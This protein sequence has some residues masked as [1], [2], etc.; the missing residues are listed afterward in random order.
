MATLVHEIWETIDDR[1]GVLPSLELAGP[2]GDDLRKR[3]H[4]DAHEEGL[5]PPRCVR[6]SEVGSHFEAMTIYYRH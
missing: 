1:G 6:T 4:E 5:E 2:D 3:L